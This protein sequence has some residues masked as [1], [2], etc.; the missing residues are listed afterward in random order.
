MSLI[1]ILD[2]IIHFA[3]KQIGFDYIRIIHTPAIWDMRLYVWNGYSVEPKYR[4]FFNLCEEEK[5][6]YDRFHTTAKNKHKRAISNGTV[7]I[8]RDRNYAYELIS[9]AGEKSVDQKSTFRIGTNHLKNLM[10]SS[11]ADKIE[12]IAAIQNGSTISWKYLFNA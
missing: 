8:A 9:I 3:E 2:E 5:E 4:Y 12:A 1:S 7:S 10:S 6:L 11:I